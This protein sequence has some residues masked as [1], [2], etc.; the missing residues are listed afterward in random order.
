MSPLPVNSTEKLRFNW[1]TPV[2]Q[3]AKNPGTIY[4]GAQ[5]LFKSVNKGET[6]QRISPDLTT[7]DPEKQKQEESGGLSVDNSS[8]E[9]HCTIFAICESPL[10]ENVVWAGTDDGNLQVTESSGSSWTNVVNNVPGLPKN[11]WV[12]SVDASKFDKN[13][14]FVTFDNHAM[15][16][17]KPYIYKTT[18]LGKTWVSVS[19][20]DINGYTH[21]IKQDIVNPNLLFAG[22]AFGLY[23]SI[24]AGAAWVQYNANVPPVEIRDI[25][26]QPETN[27]LL[28]A[29][30]GRGIFIIDDLTPYRNVTQE[31]LNSEASFLP[32]RPAYIYGGYLSAFTPNLAGF[33]KGENVTEDAVIMYYLKDRVV[34]GDVRVEIYAPDGTMLHSLPGTKRKGLNKVTW[35]MRIKPPKV[36]K[37]VSPDQSGFVAPFVAEGTYTIKLV[38]G[39]KV[40]ETQLELKINPLTP[41]SSE[42]IA[43]QRETSLKLYKMQEDL[44]F[45]VSNILK[46]QDET[47]KMIEAGK[48]SSSAGKELF[49]K[50]E[51]LRVT[52]VTIK[53]GQ[54]TGEEKLR[55][56]LGWVYLSVTFFN[57]RPTDSQLDRTRSLET[58][59]QEV[60]KKADD[61]YKS[62]LSKV[63]GELKSN[64]TTEIQIMTRDE[65]DKM[66][67]GSSQKKDS[68]FESGR[69]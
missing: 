40:I 9:N 61:I 2:H 34:T 51:D 52:L 59:L 63:N 24:D 11:T 3:S 19:T 45:I 58:E 69:E 10:D 23:I 5:F 37:A 29:T 17:M 38:R 43:L 50:L 6:W 16:D 1:N 47:N 27:D 46:V 12:S 31:I 41:C 62:Y 22:T 39:D 67:A 60:Q 28:I 68:N 42:D 53:E 48:V 7:N 57:G 21:K 20:S 54:L 44:A 36:A 49:N 14:A 15:G 25:D 65:F 56:M 4:T 66:D 13:T 55:D 32:T 18:D 8:A 30:H 35:D 33:Y 64:G 26:I